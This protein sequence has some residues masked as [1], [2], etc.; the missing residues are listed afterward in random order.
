M[1]TSDRYQDY[2]ISR[3]KKPGHAAG[4]IDAFFEE[5]DP[6]AELLKLVLSDVAEALAEDKMTLEKAKIHREK[7]DKILSQKGSD[8]IYN[9]AGWLRELG[10]KL[11]VTAEEVSE[12]ETAEAESLEGVSVS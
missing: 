9:L 3:L 5:K 1:P 10:L 6:E 4:F 8:A 2:L 12:D 7:L 11:T